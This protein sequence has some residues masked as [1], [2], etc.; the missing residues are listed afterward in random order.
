MPL[1]ISAVQFENA[2]PPTGA[3]ANAHIFQGKTARRAIVTFSDGSTMAHAV[4]APPET[5]ADELDGHLKQWLRDKYG[6]AE[7]S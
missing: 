7:A 4:A 5:P 1:S 3:Q 6:W 2:Q